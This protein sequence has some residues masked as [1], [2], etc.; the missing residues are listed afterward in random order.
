[1]DKRFDFKNNWQ[2]KILGVVL[3][4][5]EASDTDALRRYYALIDQL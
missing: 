4:L 3:W 5:W 1:M 2:R